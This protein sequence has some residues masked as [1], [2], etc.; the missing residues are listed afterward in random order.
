[1]LT[2]SLLSALQ[3]IKPFSHPKGGRPGSQPVSDE[4]LTLIKEKRRLRRQ[5][6]KAH[7][8][9]VKTRLNQLQKEIKDNLSIESQARWDKFCNDVGLETNYTESWRKIKTFS[10]QRVI[11]IIIQHCISMRKPP[12]LTQIRRNFLPNLS[13]DI[14]HSD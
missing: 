10:N 3:W 9:L 11:A 2:L 1:M 8:P 7:D 12:R 4:T 14:W 5:Y 6:S 13:K